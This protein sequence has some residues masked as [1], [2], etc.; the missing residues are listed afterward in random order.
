MRDAR[1]VMSDLAASGLSPDQL[2]LV[3]ELSATVA[4][5]ARPV[6]DEAA[7][8]RRDRDRL[9]QAERRQNRQI[10]ADSPDTADLV[11]KEYIS[12]LP[13]PSETKVST[14]AKR[15]REK[16]KFELPDWVPAEPWAAFEKM[17]K[18][19][20]GIPFTDEAKRGIVRELDELRGQG[21][22][23]E[24][25]LLKAVKKGWRSLF[26]GDDTLV[27]SS[28]RAASYAPKT[29][30]ELKRAIKAGENYDW[31][32]TDLKRQLEELNKPRRATGPPG[33][34]LGASVG[35]VMAK[36]QASA[37]V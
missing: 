36:S 24:K 12:N 29:A 33:Q 21:H 5:E 3:M 17:R 16:S 6:A 15:V 26:G 20:R 14:G 23:P 8:R 1:A 28:R 22:D 37:T 18:A 11:S 9:Y 13:A 19:M 27:A 34:S 2:A 32:V 7:D 30:D 31:D 4:A 10:S 25:L 35:R